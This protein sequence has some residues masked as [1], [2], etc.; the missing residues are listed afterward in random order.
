MLIALV[1]LSLGLLLSTF[2]NSEFQIM[3][4][5]PIIIVPQIFFTGLIPI[6][7]MSIWLQNIARIMPLYYG[8]TL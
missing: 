5:I 6:E 1:A 4:F 3:Q 7:S 2:A 8:A